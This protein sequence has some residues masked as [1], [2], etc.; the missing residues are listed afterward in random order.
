MEINPIMLL[1]SLIA[2]S[3]YNYDTRGQGS[4][5]TMLDHVFTLLLCAWS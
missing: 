3:K 4:V 5:K 1:H 2:C